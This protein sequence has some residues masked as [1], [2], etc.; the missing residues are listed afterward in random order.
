[1]RINDI[2]NGSSRDDP[3]TTDDPGAGSTDSLLRDDPLSGRADP[4]GRLRACTNHGSWS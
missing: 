1:M 2:Y 3:P 4:N